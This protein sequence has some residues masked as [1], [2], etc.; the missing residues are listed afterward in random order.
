MEQH[1]FN[2]A[3][4]VKIIQGRVNGDRCYGDVEKTLADFIHNH[5]IVEIKQ[6]LCQAKEYVGILVYTIFYNEYED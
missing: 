5:Y 2:G 6:S 3:T 1:R 4:K